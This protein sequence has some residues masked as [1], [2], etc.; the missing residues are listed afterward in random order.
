VTAADELRARLDLAAAAILDGQAIEH[1][2]GLATH[3]TRQHARGILRQLRHWQA[4]AAAVHAATVSDKVAA[5]RTAIA[6]SEADT[7]RL[8]QKEPAVPLTENVHVKVSPEE[9]RRIRELAEAEERSEG[10][11][12]RRLMAAAGLAEPERDGERA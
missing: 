8:T 4:T 6:G 11:V 10:Q 3:A 1:D 9:R 7:N 12:V 5:D 2:A